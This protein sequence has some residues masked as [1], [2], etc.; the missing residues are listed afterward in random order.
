MEACGCGGVWV[1]GIFTVRNS[2]LFP[3]HICQKTEIVV[4]KERLERVL[5]KLLVTLLKFCSP[6]TIF[7]LNHELLYN[8]FSINNFL[9]FVGDLFSNNPTPPLPGTRDIKKTNL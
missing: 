7:V 5:I 4:F 3:V 9:N 8:I 6:K 2:R 1:S